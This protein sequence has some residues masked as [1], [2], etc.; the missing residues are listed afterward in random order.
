MEGSLYVPPGSA[1]R[2][3]AE[4]VAWL[5]RLGPLLD[6]PRSAAI[7]MGWLEDT[8]ELNRLLEAGELAGTVVFCPR[9]G[10]DVAWVPPRE[11]VRGVARFGDA[12]AVRGQFSIIHGGEP[13]ASSSLGV[14]AITAERRLALA[15]DPVDA[16]G[17][18]DCFWVFATLGRF[19]VDVLDRPLVTL[20]AVGWARYDDAPGNGH[21]Q[22]DGRTKPDATFEKR[23]RALT[24]HYGEVGAKLN[25][26]VSAAA[27]QD[28]EVVAIDRVWPRAIEAMADGIEAGALEVV[29]HGYLHLDTDLQE[30]GTVEPREFRTTSEKEAGRRLDFALD[31]A[32]RAL[33]TQPETFVAPTWSYGEGLL[34]A[35]AARE[36]PAWLPPA[37]GPVAVG[38]NAHETLLSTLEG[39]H[40]LDYGAF[41]RLADAGM[42]A[43][44]VIHGGLFDNRLAYV[45]PRKDPVT[46]AK[47]ALRRDL[48][49][50]PWADGIEWLG[51]G[52]LMKLLQTHGQ[53]QVDAEGGVSAPPGARGLVWDREGKR[54][55]G[56]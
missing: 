3:F 47:L 21:Q 2:S 52:E 48:F 7:G 38:R 36:I 24:K 46:F 23:I 45:G 11:R 13:A 29:H 56:G 14:H 32:P 49:R 40:R 39:L 9:P 18:L 20:P 17:G 27:F 34:A 26:A 4:A 5:W 44:V 42:P 53:I 33:R 51:A 31:W 25:L 37:P 10:P 55:L 28:D 16:W 12:V 15:A 54:P 41:A 1:A 50:A 22:L 6:A 8:A 43:T 19:L 30:R 35:L